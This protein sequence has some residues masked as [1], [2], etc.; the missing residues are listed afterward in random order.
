MRRVPRGPVAK[1]V[2]VFADQHNH[3][4]VEF[5]HRVQPLVGVQLLG[6][7]NGRVFPAAAPLDAI[8]RV[9][10]EVQ[11]ERPLQPHPVRLVGTRQNLCRLFRNDGAGVTA[12]NDLLRGKW[13]R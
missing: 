6:I 8:E 3:L 13:N 5:L 11:E 9:H 1:S 2:V 10:T 7:E 4:A 12:G